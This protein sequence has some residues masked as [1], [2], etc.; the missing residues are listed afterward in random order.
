MAK[1]LVFAVRDRAA[2]TFGRPFFD[3]ATGRAI[4]GFTDEANRA[5]EDNQLYKHPEDFDLYSLGSFDDDTGL[6]DTGVP[7]M[8][9]VGKDV[10][11]RA[12]KA[13]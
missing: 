3:V 12:D 1:Q 11:I 8:I 13:F 7:K 9:A 6:F 2:D 10:A 5:A 4:R